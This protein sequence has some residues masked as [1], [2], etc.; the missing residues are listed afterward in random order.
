MNIVKSASEEILLIFPTT[1]AFIRQEKIG[2][3][4]LVKQAAKERNIKVR[5]LDTDKQ[6]NRT[7]NNPANTTLS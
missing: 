5:L 1:S 7:D 4:Q 2:V 6:L 3:I